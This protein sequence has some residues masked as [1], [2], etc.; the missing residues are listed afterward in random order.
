M[1]RKHLFNT[2]SLTFFF[3]IILVLS[4][5]IFLRFDMVQNYP[6]V[7]YLGTSHRQLEIQVARIKIFSETE[8][9][10]D[11]LFIGSSM[12]WLG[13]NPEVFSESFQ[14]TT[15]QALNCFNFGIATMPA[16]AAGV[17]TEILVEEYNPTMLV[18][19]TSARDYAIP[20]EAE[21]SS[22]ILETPWV[23]YQ[24]G[25]FTPNGW[26]YSHSY[27]Y[28]NV[29]NLKRL[30]TLDQTVFTDIGISNYDRTGF[31]PKSDVARAENKMAAVE[32]AQRWLKNYQVLSENVGGLVK[33][34]E[35]SKQGKS[36]IF[37]ETPVLS[38]Y[39]NYF[40]NG[41]HDY[42]KFVA[43]VSQVSSA[44]DIPFIRTNDLSVLPSDGWWN[45]NHLNIRGANALSWWLGEQIGMLSE[46]T[47][48]LP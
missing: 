36:V 4:I 40:A 15:G 3:L 9:K 37:F 48:S 18:F 34:A 22:V 44:Y 2:A 11:C 16:G 24:S 38:D 27:F 10:I 14:K 23:Q 13:V 42:D 8:G 29:R 28:S 25:N 12:V 33:I 17:M 32:D 21:D 1:L 39:Y 31:L 41:E 7:P 35:Y 20:L 6:I 19:G 47:S 5:E 43:V 45:E 26:L 46:Y 30:L